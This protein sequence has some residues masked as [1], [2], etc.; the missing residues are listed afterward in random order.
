MMA[1]GLA[2]LAVCPIWSDLSKLISENDCGWIIN[3]SADEY[4]PKYRDMKSYLEKIYSIKNRKNIAENF[5][6]TLED[7]KKTPDLIYEKRKN[8]YLNV[9]NIQNLSKMRKF[10]N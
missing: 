8:A 5:I 1:G 2:I 9:N 10:C 3:N 7:L 4:L 6:A